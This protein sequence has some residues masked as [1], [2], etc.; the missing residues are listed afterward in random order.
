MLSN[1]LV[2]RRPWAIEL[3]KRDTYAFSS[4]QILVRIEACGICGT[5]LGIVSGAYDA[6]PGV[7]LGHEASGVVAE[8]GAEVNSFRIGDRVVID[9]TYFCGRCFYC[10]TGRSNH[11][12]LKHRTEAGVSCDGCFAA[13]YAT[14]PQFLRKI[15]NSVTFEA[16]C[17]T[18][19]LSCVITGFR[20]FRTGPQLSA[21]VIGGGTI[22]ILYALLFL[23]ANVDVCVAE[24]SP[25]RRQLIADIT[26]K[27]IPGAASLD[28][29]V[30]LVSRRA[31]PVV[32]M[33]VDTGGG[34]TG[35]SLSH[36]AR[37][38]QLACIAL[39]R[40]RQELDIGKL[41]NESI[42]VFGSV[43]SLGGSFDDALA[44]IEKRLIPA[45][46]IVTDAMPL[47]LFDAAFA[48]L[49]IDLASKTRK[50]T[51]D[52]MKIVLEPQE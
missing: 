21:V 22:G 50:P 30:R 7:I 13:Y 4:Q 23:Q 6:S 40:V 34:Q 49:G 45:E 36:L 33:I 27:A 8:V 1:S 43:D 29:A 48:R 41:A 47:T 52:A 38:G 20:Q 39:K 26:N 37:G 5:D 19:P 42:S 3:A 9:P 10:R 35:E 17:L 24:Q 28:D 46:R 31:P 16:A 25:A 11:C 51:A 14:Q 44:M 18:E 32:D 15:P 2:Y 12:E